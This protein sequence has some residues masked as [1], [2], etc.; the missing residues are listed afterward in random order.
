MITAS[1]VAAQSSAV[2]G[3]RETLGAIRGNTDFRN[4]TAYSVGRG[5]CVLEAGDC[6]Q[7]EEKVFLNLRLVI[8]TATLSSSGFKFVKVDEEQTTFFPARFVS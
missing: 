2:D 5:L 3:S 6:R 7:P 4:Q 8:G 1:D